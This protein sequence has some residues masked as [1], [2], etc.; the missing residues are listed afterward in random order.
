MKLLKE[1]GHTPT[2]THSTPA[3]N[4]LLHVNDKGSVQQGGYQGAE[5]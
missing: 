4:P 5:L 2:Q 3:A 1:C